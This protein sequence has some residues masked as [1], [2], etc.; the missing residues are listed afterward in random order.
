MEYTDHIIRDHHIFNYIFYIIYLF[1][2]DKTEFTGIESYVYELAF[3]QK[4]IT[5]FPIDQ[6]YIA[7][8]GEL[9]LDDD[10]DDDDDDD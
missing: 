7:K 4:D 1:K 6:L 5:W 8:P 2:K 10:E 9:Q 3:N